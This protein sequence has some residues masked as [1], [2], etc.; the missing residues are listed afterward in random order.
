MLTEYVYRCE[1]PKCSHEEVDYAHEDGRKCNWCGHSMR[2]ISKSD[3]SFVYI[4]ETNR[5]VPGRKRK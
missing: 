2:L 4:R 3:V 1:G 5:I